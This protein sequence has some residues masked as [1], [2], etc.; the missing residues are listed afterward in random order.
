M[1]F[2]RIKKKSPSANS[3]ISHVRKEAQLQQRRIQLS[4]NKSNSKPRPKIQTTSKK[5]LSAEAPI[6]PK[7]IDYAKGK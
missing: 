7:P 6:S 1:D 4:K 3:S 5:N 2:K